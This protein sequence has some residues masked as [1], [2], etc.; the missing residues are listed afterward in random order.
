[1]S[2]QEGISR[3]VS[4]ARQV[5]FN[6]RAAKAA[7]A[8]VIDRVETGVQVSKDVLTNPVKRA[9]G[10]RRPDRTGLRRVAGDLS[11]P[12]QPKNFWF[13][14]ASVLRTDFETAK[15]I[16]AS[17]T[18]DA[19]A[20]TITRA[21]G[22]WI[23]DGVAVNDVILVGGVTGADNFFKATVT[24]VTALVL[25]VDDVPITDAVANASAYVIVSGAT[26]S[27]KTT[28]AAGDGYS[29]VAATKTIT[30]GGGGGGSFLVDGWKVGEVLNLPQSVPANVGKNFTITNVTALTLVVSEEI[31]SDA[32]P[33]DTGQTI[34]RPGGVATF[35]KLLANKQKPFWTLEDRHPA[36]TVP[37]SLVEHGVVFNTLS[38]DQT[39]T[40]IYDATFAVIGKNFAKL[41]AT[42]TP[43]GAPYFTNERDMDQAIEPFGGVDLKVILNGV[44]YCEVT[45]FSMEL[46]NNITGL[47][48]FCR[49]DHQQGG[50]I[51]KATYGAFTASGSLTIV[52][53]AGE[54]FDLF[55]PNSASGGGEPTLFPITLFFQSPNLAA[56][57]A[58]APE[59]VSFHFPNCKITGY[60]TDD[61]D[62]PVIVTCAWTAYERVD[63]VLP[64]KYA[65][66]TCFCQDS[67]Q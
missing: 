39:P 60:T 1:M 41:I 27:K 45:S 62:G 44:A 50:G 12:F 33:N 59:F 29:V 56:G 9:S 20:N 40:D 48:A 2:E 49:D 67:T 7:Y 16:A 36:M 43:A 4:I 24:V 35:P 47:E 57:R 61:P 37:E 14:I 15:K 13:A 42:D 17:L 5:A 51:A 53:E 52:L 25:T 10:Q 63:T 6:T 66:T 22:S 34:V 11:A 8:T 30:R 26:Q 18:F 64:S 58:N 46:S 31:A 54:I 21:A 23:A 32:G 55:D 28:T 38:L 65:Q 3:V 19:G